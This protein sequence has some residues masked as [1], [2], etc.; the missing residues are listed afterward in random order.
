MLARFARINPSAA[1]DLGSLVVMV[2]VLAALAVL[3]CA[4]LNARVAGAEVLVEEAPA[5]VA[6]DELLDDGQGDELA[7]V[8]WVEPCYHEAGGDR[9][10]RALDPRPWLAYHLGDGLAG[11]LA[12]ALVELLVAGFALGVGW[13]IA[14]R[15]V[16][17][18]IWLAE[19]AVRL[20]GCAGLICCA[21]AFA[22]VAA[23]F[24]LADRIRGRRPAPS[25]RR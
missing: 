8:A 18:A 4:N 24:W 21:V 11:D 16:K 10:F 2:V 9:G 6:G 5:A 1:A 7:G 12:E 22:V 3:A 15:A 23:P 25:R 14:Q 17:A 19:L 20:V 13:S